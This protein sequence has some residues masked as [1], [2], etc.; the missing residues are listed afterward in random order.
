MMPRSATTTTFV[1]TSCTQKL[2]R[3]KN[4]SF[5]TEKECPLS[6][7]LFT[8][9]KL[10]P[11][12]RIRIP[13]TTRETLMELSKRVL[14]MRNSHPTCVDPT[15]SIALFSVVQLSLMVKNANRIPLKV[16][17]LEHPKLRTLVVKDSEVS[18]Q[19]PLTSSVMIKLTTTRVHKT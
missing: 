16:E 1:A 12:T 10:E 15:P 3:P 11:H 8:R 2:T 7:D 17:F 14:R 5:K 19:E 4:K 9:P 18:V 13:L 6:K